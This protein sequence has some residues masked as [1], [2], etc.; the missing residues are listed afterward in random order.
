M[1]QRINFKD[2]VIW[3]D[4]DYCVINKPS[5]ISTLNDRNDPVN[6]LSMARE[7]YSD[8]QV[9]HRLDKETSGAL[10]IAKNPEAY[11]HMSL[12][13]E[14]R[15]IEK[16]YHAVADGIHHFQNKVVEDKILKLSNGTVRIDRNGKEAKTTFNTLHAYKGHTLIECKP[17]SG[18]MHQIRIHL[19]NHGASITGD[20]SYGGKHFY[21]SNI[22]KKF[23]LKKDT[24]EQPL[25]KRIALHAYKLTFSTLNGEKMTVQA[26]YPKD[27]K[28]LV[29]QLEKNK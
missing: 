23:H 11:R 17:L 2:L 6:I 8:A 16:V 18:R 4:A 10:I 9:C 13:F 24:E 20:I 15:S 22:K 19:A 26:D 7:A 12:Q 1:A 14:N 28:V 27:F 29:H 3:E 5:F 21:L 25:L